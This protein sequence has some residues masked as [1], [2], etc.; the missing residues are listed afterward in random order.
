MEEKQTEEINNNEIFMKRPRIEKPNDEY[1]EE[2][3][4][5]EDSDSDSELSDYYNTDAEISNNYK[6][7]MKELRF[8]LLKQREKLKINNHKIANA[9]LEF[10]IDRELIDENEETAYDILDL[11]ITNGLLRN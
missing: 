5:S 4:S 1:I 7:E 2:S 3:I 10:I 8:K 6:N 9:L 11:I